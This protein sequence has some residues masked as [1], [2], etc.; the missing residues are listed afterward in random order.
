MSSN[1]SVQDNVSSGFSLYYEPWI[2]VLYTS[3]EIQTVSLKQLFED[4]YS[5][6]KIHSGDATT[7]VAIL[8]VATVVLFR[9]ILTDSGEYG[10]LYTSPKN[11]I[12]GVRSGDPERLKFIFDYLEKYQ[13]RFDLF[14]AERPFM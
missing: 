8:G 10:E 1:Q 13:N 6:R 14:D 11:W 4:G 2:P 3:G 5:I 9:A 12:Q 7:D